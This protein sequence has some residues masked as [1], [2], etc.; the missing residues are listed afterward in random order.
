MSQALRALL[1]AA[2]ETELADRPP[3]RRLR[4]VCVRMEDT[5]P[6]DWLCAQCLSPRIYW[7]GRDDTREYASVGCLSPLAADGSS[8]DHDWAYVCGLLGDTPEASAFLGMRF[9]EESEVAQEW[10]AFGARTFVIPEFML[11]REGAE[12]SIRANVLLTPSVSPAEILDDFSQRLEALALAVP[13]AR[14]FSTGPTVHHERPGRNDWLDQVQAL[15][16]AVG[17][18]DLRKVVLARRLDLTFEGAP[19]PFSLMKHFRAMKSPAY[20]FCWEP[21]PGCAFLGSSP[22]QLVT[23]EENRVSSEAL[24]GTRRRGTSPRED[25]ALGAALLHDAKDRHEHALV[26]EHVLSVFDGLCERVEPEEA[27]AVLQLILVQHLLQRTVGWLKPGVTDEAIV[28][29]LH[30]TPA[31]GGVPTGAALSCIRAHEPFDRG[32]YAAPL[33][34]ISRDKADLTVAIRSGLLRGNTLSLYCGAGI[35]SA[36]QP[37]AEWL[38]TEVKFENFLNVIH[39]D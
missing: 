16:K 33:G 2:L 18:D 17:G 22:E 7:R 37:E 8:R 36:S 5:D 23:R 14:P 26:H 25:A 3:G 15:A 34:L 21:T 39:A 32:W 4:S 12:T 13:P 29:A 6:V 19:D 20:F 24:A 10:Q 35:V 1:R 31:V 30:P 28:K 9:D 27:P 38:E 11:V